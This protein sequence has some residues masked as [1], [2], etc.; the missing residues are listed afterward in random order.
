MIGRL[1][2][3]TDPHQK[4]SRRNPDA[5]GPIA[6]PAPEMPAQMA[7]AL[8]RSRPGNTFVR[9]DSVE[10]MTNAAPT[11]ITARETITIAESSANAPSREPSPN[12]TRPACSAPLRPKRS[13]RAAAVNSSPAKIEAV[14]VDDPLDLGVAGPDAAELRRLLHRRQRHVE[15]GVA[16]DHDHQ[17]R[18]QDGED[19]PAPV[20]DEGVDPVVLVGC[21]IR[22]YGRVSIL[23]PVP[24]RRPSRTSSPGVFVSCFRYA[25]VVT[26]DASPWS[27]FLRP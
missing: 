13:P 19:L 18:A 5:I 3:N 26:A 1:T 9:I 10:G 23:V 8:A 24:L 6:A 12:T 20:V 2:R 25:T 11:P 21:D 4:C 14:G 27:R 17:R 16:D 15:D 7:I 22:R